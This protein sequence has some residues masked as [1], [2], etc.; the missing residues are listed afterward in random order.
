M[1]LTLVLLCSLSS[2]KATRGPSDIAPSLPATTKEEEARFDAII[3]RFILADTGRLRGEDARKAVKEFDALKAEAIPA[4]IRGLNKAARINHS[5]PV[6]MIGKKLSRML[7]SSSD[8]VLLEYARDELADSARNTPHAVPIQNLRVQLMLRKN[9]V[10]RLALPPLPKELDR[11]PTARLITMAGSER[12]ARKKTVLEEL[13]KRDGREAMLALARAASSPDRDAQKA[14]RE[15]LD[16]YLARQ[17][18]SGIKEAM[19]EPGAE[20]RKS[21]IRV[22]ATNEGLVAAIIER[23]TDERADVR[24]EARAVLVKLAKGE[25]HGPGPKATRAEQESARRQW[26]AWWEKQG[27]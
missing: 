8:A 15:A 25:D 17:S 2:E 16:G 11:V 4:L 7:L 10:E 23:L 3:D 14:G 27:K 20:V 21:A 26:Q 9:A 24:A 1:L 18:M 5:C 13:A 6:L 22:A 12:G 19:V